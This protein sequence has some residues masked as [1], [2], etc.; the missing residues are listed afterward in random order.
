[1]LPRATTPP[2]SLSWLDAVF[3]ATSAVC[4]TGLVV[5]DTATTFTPLGLSSIIA[6]C[7]LG[8]LGIVT[9]ATVFGMLVR[10]DI[11]IREKLLLQNVVASQ[12]FGEI[13]RTIYR[14]A[15]LTFLLEA[16]GALCLYVALYEAVPATGQRLWCAVFHAISEF[17]NAGFSTFS[18]SLAGAATATHLGVNATVMVLIVLGGLGFSVLWDSWQWIM[19]VVRGHTSTRWQKFLVG[20]K[21]LPETNSLELIANQNALLTA[22]K[23]SLGCTSE[24]RRTADS[25][26]RRCIRCTRHVVSRRHLG[27][28]T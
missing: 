11:G 5:V 6:L 16:I 14:I 2:G 4:V 3:T 28:V 27:P 13:S 23:L 10:G 15:G 8:G 22:E 21:V 18:E 26:S 19:G 9:F 1:M 17:C 7:Q 24:R 20:Y 25:I 12:Q